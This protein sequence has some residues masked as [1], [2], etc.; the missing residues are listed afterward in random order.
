MPFID[1]TDRY[2]NAMEDAAVLYQHLKEILGVVTKSFNTGNRLGLYFVL[3]NAH[4]FPLLS[5][6]VG[7][8]WEERFFRCWKRARE[9]AFRLG[10]NEG[11][12]TSWESRDPTRGHLGG[13]VRVP[14]RDLIL[15][16]DGLREDIDAAVGLA[17]V[18]A[19]YREIPYETLLEINRRFSTNPMLEILIAKMSD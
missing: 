5:F 18:R 16:V 4:G 17:L 14:S 9:K 1:I 8:I 10:K 3:A 7:K 13:A 6:G 2:T 11:H 19:V 12:L 15:S